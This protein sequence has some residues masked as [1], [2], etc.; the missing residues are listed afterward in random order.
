MLVM[1]RRFSGLTSG[2]QR[3]GAEALNLRYAPLLNLHERIKFSGRFADESDEL[4]MGIF[5]EP[6][7]HSEMSLAPEKEIKDAVNNIREK[8]RKRMSDHRT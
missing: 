4:E 6:F 2:K 1:S 7:W 3:I 5:N 8:T